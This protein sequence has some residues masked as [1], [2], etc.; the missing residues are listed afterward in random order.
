MPLPI[1]DL[2]TS[3]HICAACAA[4]HLFRPDED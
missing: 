3:L 2:Q 4:N 1:G